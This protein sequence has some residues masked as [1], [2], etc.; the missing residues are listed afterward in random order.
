MLERV[1][2][3]FWSIRRKFATWKE[4]GCQESTTVGTEG[5]DAVL[6]DVV[7]ARVVGIGFGC[8]EAG[9]TVNWLVKGV[10]TALARTTDV[11]RAVAGDSCA[12][13][14]S[15]CRARSQGGGE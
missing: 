13:P 8:L 2:D 5:T 9:V 4:A 10:L 14:S 7:A 12:R 15:L 11:N 1:E 6:F 3:G